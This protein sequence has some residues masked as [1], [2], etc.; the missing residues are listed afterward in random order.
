MQAAELRGASLGGWEDVFNTISSV[1]TAADKTC[2][3]VQSPM[4]QAMA[5]GTGAQV[6]GR[7]GGYITEA[8]SA[9]SKTC[10]AIPGRAGPSAP[11]SRYPVGSVA[12]FHERERIF[13]I[14]PPGSPLSGV[15][16]DR[17]CQGVG[18][19][20]GGGLGLEP[21]IG[22]EPTPPAGAVVGQPIKAVYKRWWFWPAILGGGA[23]VA[24]GAYLA[25]RKR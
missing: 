25:L 2:K 9:L 20:A 13:W 24:G 15:S 16:E 10:S 5:A 6:G 22:K 23:V 11:S 21:V 4:T 14:F 18:C 8:A 3:V 1:Y 7:Y 19:L 17:F 12:R